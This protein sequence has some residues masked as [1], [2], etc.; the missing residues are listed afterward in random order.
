MLLINYYNIYE[1]KKYD[2][3]MDLKIRKCSNGYTY[4]DIGCYII[5]CF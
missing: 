1:D 4:F 2:F 3:K 5:C